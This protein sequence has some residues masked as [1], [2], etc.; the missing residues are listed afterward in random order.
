MSE[1]TFDVGLASKLKQAV[2]R[3]NIT[4]LADIDWLCDGNNLANVRRVRLGH[5][6]ITVPEHLIDC[7]ADPFVPK[8]WKV[9]EHQ[10]GGAFK[11]DASQ[12]TLHL[13]KGQKNGGYVDGNKLRILLAGKPVL[14]ANVLDYM[15]K[16]PHLIS[17]DWK[18]DEKGNTRYIFF[19]GTIYRDSDGRLCVPYL[20]WY[21]SGWDWSYYWLGNDFYGSNPAALRAS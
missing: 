9:E 5:A 16:N 18:K 17:D 21:G 6:V 13:D 11:W 7:D 10:K 15:L 14:N 4:D 20:Y 19:W 2:I 8:G 3:N 12:V 1:L